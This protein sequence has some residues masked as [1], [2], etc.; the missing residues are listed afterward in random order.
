MNDNDDDAAEFAA[1]REALKQRINPL[2]RELLADNP[3][4]KRFFETV[5]DTADGDPAA[6]PWADLAPKA[7]LA[8]WLAA[9]PGGGRTAVD[10][11]CGLGDNAEA[12]AAAG[13]RT[14]AFDLSDKAI[15]WA[16][17]RFAGTAVDYRA[18]NL[19]DLPADWPPA[20]D[21]VNE[22]YTIQSVPPPLH[23]RFSERIA[24][25]VAPGG[26]LLVYARTRAENTDHDGPPWPLMPSE[27]DVFA[28]FGLV[29]QRENLFVVERP[30]RRIAHVFSVWKRG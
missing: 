26:R 9:N 19:L 17:E 6:V 27:Y 11:A 22:C 18:A 5:Y 10:I 15:G 24:A 29:R 23:R 13:Y 21:L 25:L 2:D 7:E 4:R 1:R 16:R 3:D 14:M 28:E 8:D 12:I 30:D 20:F